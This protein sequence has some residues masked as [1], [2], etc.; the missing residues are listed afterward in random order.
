MLGGSSEV[1]G[2]SSLILKMGKLRRFRVGKRL[3]RDSQ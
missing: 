1:S 2:F 3:T